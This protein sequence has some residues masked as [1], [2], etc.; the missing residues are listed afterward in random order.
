LDYARETMKRIIDNAWK[1]A[2]SVLPAS[3]YSNYLRELAYFNIT[4]SV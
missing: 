2:E 1:E 3:K 4:R